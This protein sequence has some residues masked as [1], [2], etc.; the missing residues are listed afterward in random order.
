M[1]VVRS[2]Y[3]RFEFLG[4]DM[5]LNVPTSYLFIFLESIISSLRNRGIFNFLPKINKS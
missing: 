2:K 5:L 4:S 1:N 3:Q